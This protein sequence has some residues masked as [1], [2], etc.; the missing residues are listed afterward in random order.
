MRNFRAEVR[1]SGN[2]QELLAWVLA[3]PF[4]L[5]VDTCAHSTGRTGRVGYAIARERWH[6]VPALNPA[7]YCARWP[8]TV[9]VRVGFRT[10]DSGTTERVDSLLPCAER[11]RD[12]PIFR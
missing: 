9:R 1:R 8:W 10:T 3:L 7:P 2:W 4:L 12:E 11:A 6:P 5:R